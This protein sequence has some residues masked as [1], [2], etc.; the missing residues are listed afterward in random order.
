M[1][2]NETLS[3]Q[4]PEDILGY[5]PHMLGYC[6]EDSLV[7]ITMQGKALGAT[8]RVDLP[9]RTPSS[10]RLAAWLAAFSD[11]IRGYL[12]SDRDADGVLLVVYTDHGWSDHT[13]TSAATPLLEALQHSLDEVGLPVRDAWLVGSEYW[14]SAYCSDEQCC[15]QPGLPVAMIT[16]S[17]LSAEMVFRGSS[18]GPSPRSEHQRRNSSDAICLGPKVEAAEARFSLSL[19][20]RWRSERCFDA[21]LDVW[22]GV[23]AGSRHQVHLCAETDE[24]LIGFLR[25]TLKVPAWRDAVVVMSAAGS[26][27][28]KSGAE[29]F[30]LFSG[31]DSDPLPFDPYL[32]GGQCFGAPSG[33]AGTEEDARRRG[34][35]GGDSE[36]ARGGDPV[37]GEDMDR[38][39][40]YTYGDVLLGEQPDIPDWSCMDALQRLLGV[41]CGDGE[42]GEASAAALTLQAWVAWCKGRGSHAH[43]C[44]VRALEACPGY[45]FAELFTGILGE[46]SLC[47]WARSP[48]SAWRRGSGVAS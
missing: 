46:G 23:L 2:T 38:P 9:Q 7:A 47:G 3:I 11:Q 45:R 20:G 24:D 17:H 37:R 21:V 27:C 31:D 28:A 19:S 1:T 35:V 30:G 15:P 8:L 4:Q 39:G 10:S 16:N 43:A 40:V 25:A 12:I 14:R 36:R 13:V 26:E 29:A 48:E 32:L 5:V 33:A 6:P 41:L 34:G 18:I 44:L 42:Q 22:R